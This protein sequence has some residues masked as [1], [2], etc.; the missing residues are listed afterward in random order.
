MRWG[1]ILSWEQGISTEGQDPE[2]DDICGKE[3]ECRTVAYYEYRLLS[4]Q[5][6]LQICF[7]YISTADIFVWNSVVDSCHLIAVHLSMKNI[8]IWN[9][10]I[11]GRCRKNSMWYVREVLCKWGEWLGS[12]IAPKPY[13]SCLI[14]MVVLIAD[15][16]LKLHSKPFNKNTRHLNF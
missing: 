5:I 12:W 9:G 13:G 1:W 15:F 4:E 3:G 2:W 11:C 7:Y 16:Q 6:H 10:Q 8:V 14:F